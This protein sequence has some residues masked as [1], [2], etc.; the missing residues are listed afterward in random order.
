[1][2]EFVRFVTWS[3]GG[4]LVAGGL[5]RIFVFDV[6]TM[7]D[8]KWLS[9]STAPTLQGG[10]TLLLL[11]RGTAGPGEL[12]RCAEPQKKPGKFV[13]GRIVGIPGDKLEIGGARITLNG[14]LFTTTEACEES[15]FSVFNP[16]T[17]S[18]VKLNC[19]RIEMAGGWHFIGI[20]P[21]GSHGRPHNHT[22][23]PGRFFI[24][25]DNRDMHDDSRD[26]GALPSE[27]CDRRIVFRLWSANGWGDSKRRLTFIR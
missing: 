10:D 25:S 8:D 12:V 14:R 13:V 17:N 26:F 15:T 4:L 6:W 20:N 22:V 18:V 23:G 9:A 2:S 5:L 27:T 7:P 21:K 24:A 3:A 16:K 1:M 19:S 11:K